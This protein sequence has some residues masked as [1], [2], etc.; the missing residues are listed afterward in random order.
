[1]NRNAEVMTGVNI[2]NPIRFE[3]HKKLESNNKIVRM[4]GSAA[5]ICR[6]SDEEYPTFDKYCWFS[7]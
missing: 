7:F 2:T 6:V 1:M 3:I 4:K 5:A